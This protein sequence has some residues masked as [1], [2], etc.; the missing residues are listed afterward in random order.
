MRNFE[1]SSWTDQLDA[2]SY[3]VTIEQV[4]KEMHEKGGMLYNNENE[5]SNS[6][7]KILKSR[8]IKGTLTGRFHTK[9]G[10]FWTKD[11]EK[12]LK[13]MFQN[14][15]S[16]HNIAKRLQRTLG[17]IEA[18]LMKLELIDNPHKQKRY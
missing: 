12:C 16:R 14:G 10:Q 17:A 1:G 5:W 6:D 11:D 13:V 15:K 18:R 9:A 4:R 7:K 3:A 2:C 8:Q